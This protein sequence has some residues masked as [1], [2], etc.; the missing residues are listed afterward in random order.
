MKL[1]RF[2]GEKL[3]DIYINFE[4]LLNL[5]SKLQREVF[6]ESITFEV[7][8]NVFMIWLQS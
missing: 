7:D 2:P 3:S 8:C 5:R 1:E 4:D 6:A